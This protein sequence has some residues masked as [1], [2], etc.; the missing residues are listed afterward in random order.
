ERVAH[1]VDAGDGHGGGRTHG[2]RIVRH[3]P[4]LAACTRGFRGVDAASW[5]GRRNAQRLRAGTTRFMSRW[6]TSST[7]WR[8]L[9]AMTSTVPPSPPRSEP[10]ERAATTSETP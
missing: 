3:T 6:A 9:V 8:P 1:L 5:T 4:E 10:S 7:S 2:L